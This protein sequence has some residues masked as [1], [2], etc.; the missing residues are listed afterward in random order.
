[1]ASAEDVGPAVKNHPPTAKMVCEAIG[2]LN[3]RSGSSLQAIKKYVSDTYLLD[4]HRSGTYVTKYIKK[5]VASGELV[6]TKGHGAVG[7]F[8]LA[9]KANVKPK[10]AKAMDDET[11]TAAVAT[12][13]AAMK[14]AAT[15]AAA[16]KPAATKAAATKPAATKAAA[17]KPAATKPAATKAAAAKPAATKAAAT[18]PAAT[19]PEASKAAATKPAASK[20]TAKATAKAAAAKPATSKAAEPIAAVPKPKA[21]AAT[22]QPKKESKKES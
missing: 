11:E 1:M 15:K 13:S 18:K 12:K 22:K 9:P 16:A 3:E 14:P 20:A 5:A 6:Q 17:T 21:T 8:K 10:V 7:S 4:P 19:K 2:T